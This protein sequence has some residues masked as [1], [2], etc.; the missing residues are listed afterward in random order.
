MIASVTFST[1][2]TYSFLN[3]HIVSKA[4]RYV[5]VRLF[6][7]EIQLVKTFN[8]YIWAGENNKVINQE[9]TFEEKWGLLDVTD[10][11]GSILFSSRIISD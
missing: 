9:G 11:N 4:N 7:E 6:N 1:V 10:F 8:W 2:H 3:L 5:I